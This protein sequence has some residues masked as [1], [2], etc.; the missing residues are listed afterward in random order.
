MTNQTAQQTDEQQQEQER[1]Q[2]ASQT[3]E[4]QTEERTPGEEHLGDPGKRALEAMKGERN[5]AR[6]ERDDWKR[7]Y[8]E[9]KA[10]LDG[11][12]A[13]H[14]QETERQKIRDEALSK[15]NIRIASASLRAAAAGKLADPGDAAKW[16]DPTTIEVDD[17][18][19]VDESAL[20]AKIDDLLKTKPYLA[21]QGGSRF[22][23]SGDG[24]PRKA[25]QRPSQLTQADLKSM[26]PAD[27]VKAEKDGRL[28]DLLNRK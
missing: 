12:E 5:T 6:G 22:Q 17:D 2:Q 24:G 10:K 1:A 13:E 25:D 8:D 28:E 16:I 19:T 7:Q 23:G 26:S 14:E 3:T 21:A 9:L 4:Q 15:A 18:G 11:R 27:I 20:A